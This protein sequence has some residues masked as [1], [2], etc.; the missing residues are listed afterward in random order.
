VDP[1]MLAVRLT[2]RSTVGAVR[3]AWSA[4]VLADAAATEVVAN[5]IVSDDHAQMRAAPVDLLLTLTVPR[6]NRAE[7]LPGWTTLVTAAE[8]VR[9]WVVTPH[10]QIVWDRTWPDGTT[11]P[12][13]KMVSFM[14][15]APETT[16][17]DFAEHWTQRHTPLA[18]R[19]HPGLWNY[20]QN[21]VV[22]SLLTAGDDIDGIAELH[23]RSRESFEREFF[24]SD[25]GRAV[26]LA[27]IPRFMAPPGRD[28]SLM[29]ET[30]LRTSGI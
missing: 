1:V 7:S 29:T 26:I 25:E 27:D 30:P 18:R 3:S 17:A 13:V 28:G 15:R 23:F 2:D 12:G 10:R 4:A 6:A 19:H 14:R 21:V 11:A 8:E 16:A 5:E 22:R 24:D 20:T 9:A